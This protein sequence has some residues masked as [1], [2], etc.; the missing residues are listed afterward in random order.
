MVARLED[1]DAAFCTGYDRL[2]FE[3]TLR[4]GD[5]TNALAGVV[6]DRG[7]R[8][9]LLAGGGD[10][11]VGGALAGRGA[12]RERYRAERVCRSQTGLEHVPAVLCTGGA[13]GEGGEDGQTRSG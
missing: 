6:D 5:D 8:A 4:E 12:E 1:L 13:R 11:G 3:A 2:F 9:A 10:G 7:D